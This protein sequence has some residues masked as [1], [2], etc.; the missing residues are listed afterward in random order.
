MKK[1]LFLLFTFAS[2]SLMSQTTFSGTQLPVYVGDNSNSG[3]KGNILEIEATATNGSRERLAKFNLSNT[4][5]TEVLEF[6]N[7]TDD[8]SHFL[9]V[10]QGY[11]QSSA[12]SGLILI[13]SC[14]DGSDIG[15]SPLLTFDSR[16]YTDYYGSGNDD[17]AGP[18]GVTTRP[19]FGWQEN[20]TRHMTMNADG[21]LG[22]GTSAPS[23]TLHTDG[24][25]R[26]ENL[27][28]SSENNILVIDASGNL[29]YKSFSSFNSIT[30]NCV[31]T[32]LITKSNASGN[33]DCS[34]IYDDGTGVGI[35]TS[36]PSGRFEVLD[37]RNSSSA[38]THHFYFHTTSPSGNNNANLMTMSAARGDGASGWLLSLSNANGEAFRIA[39]NRNVGVNTT[40]P[41]A[42]FHVNGSV[43]FEGTTTNNSLS[44]ILVIDGSGNLYKR[45]A[46]T[47][48]GGI[49]NS[50]T[51]TNYIPKVSGS[52]GD[53]SCSQIQDDG[54]TVGI[55][56]IQNTYLDASSVT[57]N[58]RLYVNGNALFTG[59]AFETS[60]KRK[61]TN[62]NQILNSSDIL[63][64]LK[65]YS[66]N[67]I[68]SDGSLGSAT[69][70]VMAQEVQKVAPE[71][72]ITTEDGTLAVNYHGLI[73]ILIEA[74]NEQTKEIELQ[75]TKIQEL[76]S[77]LNLLMAK[78]NDLE[79]AENQNIKNFEFNA[80]P[81]P[82]SKNQG[83]TLK[84]EIPFDYQEAKVVIFNLNGKLINTQ[85]I[86]SKTETNINTSA[87]EAGIYLYTI[88]VD[89]IEGTMK[90]VVLTN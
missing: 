8:N 76:E 79:G 7:G 81:N 53:L 44:S 48:G 4:D 14:D 54:S 71:L 18:E 63:N 86:D 90:K 62:I 61:K 85:L 68:Q 29:G 12:G 50:C 82:T 40:T 26:F 89:G 45:D 19:L 11:R 32:N 83:L 3:A 20:G 42:K 47:L 60:D 75:N 16:T 17:P 31:T 78:M 33:L 6:R 74:N 43:R 30:N 38:G 1:V 22:I 67:L 84:T 73:P 34:Q 51:T 15:S 5:T 24:T 2:L 36:S 64:G 35:N 39:A 9:P 49:S 25:V 10:I 80:V 58:L 56:G 77:K 55:N 57:H 88:I 28:T 13:G 65:G 69:Y 23:A 46:S 87:M 37:D 72:V 27:T 59:N 41:S 52:S 66:Y 21:Q 70:G